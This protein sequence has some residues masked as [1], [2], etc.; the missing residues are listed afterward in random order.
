LSTWTA[1]ARGRGR[2]DRA[3]EGR[4]S[5]SQA[6]HPM[7]T[8]N[9]LR[10][11]AP[12][13]LAALTAAIAMCAISFLPRARVIVVAVNVVAT[14]ANPSLAGAVA[15][16]ASRYVRRRGFFYP[17]SAWAVRCRTVVGLFGARAS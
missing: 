12:L 3:A 14:S 8:P 13:A 1:H 9:T 6:L 16:I 4:L 15:D 2:C 5:T 10:T 7:S 11:R 17:A